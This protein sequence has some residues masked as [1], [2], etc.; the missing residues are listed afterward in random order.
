M[1]KL[2][3]RTNHKYLLISL[4]VISLTYSLNVLSAESSKLENLARYPQWLKLLHYEKPIV[5][6][7]QAKSV[8]HSDD[9]FLAADGAVNAYSEIKAI[10]AEMNALVIEKDKH[11]RCRFPARVAFI[12]KELKISSKFDTK[13]NCPALY[14]W[15]KEDGITSISVVLATGYLGNPASYYGHTLL[16]FNEKK[17]EN[18]SNL[19][20]K[21][22]NYGA[23]STRGDNPVIYIAKSVLGGYDAGFSNIDFYFHENTYGENENRDLWEY[24]L[25]LP[26]EDLKLVVWHAY[27]VLSKKYTYYFFRQ[28]CAYRMADILQILPGLDV[29]PHFRPYTI[30]Q[31]IVQKIRDAELAGK[32]LLAKT[33]Y[34]PSRQSRF[35]AKY[36]QL[37]ANQKA[38][39]KRMVLQGVDENNADFKGL[40][41]ESKHQIIDT[42]IDY[43]RFSSGDSQLAETKID[44]NYYLAIASRYKLP[45]GKT[46][47]TLTP[48][49]PPDKGRPPSWAQVGTIFTGAEGMATSFRIRPAYYDQLDSDGTHVGN[50][51]L[52]M[53]DTQLSLKN[54]ELRLH[55]LDFVRVDS[56]N[57]GLSGLPGDRNF[58]WKIRVGAEQDKAGCLNCLIVRGQS[59]IG[60][61]IQL[62]KHSFIAAYIGGALQS[63]RYDQGAA[64]ARVSAEVI[65]RFNDELSS[66]LNIEYR[67]G[68]GR[69]IYEQVFYRAD[70]RWALTPLIDLR[71]GY[72]AMNGANSAQTLQTGLGMYW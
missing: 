6:P 52:I 1:S 48:S 7:G 28:N 12:E 56:A 29:V 59:D 62:N 61:G 44:Q 10:Y 71:V 42:I 50:A 30:P 41:V 46:Q 51:S 21:T 38:I 4:F 69:G 53:G 9:F 65:S 31:T 26:A 25:N 22:V 40:T 11:V 5:L 45:P 67:Q 8:I 20:D 16:K 32:P 23:T 68:L 15:T 18:N 35:Y 37:D 54:G 66:K 17:K 33:I 70:L 39:L 58:S 43:Y 19:L 3:T 64:F 2:L 47:E 57:P 36:V 55:H 63:Y 14:E 49:M 34:H 72:E 13:N 27:E 24:E 60:M